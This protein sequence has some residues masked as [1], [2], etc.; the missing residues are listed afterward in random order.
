MATMYPRGSVGV[1]RHSPATAQRCAEEQTAGCQ[2]AA[3]LKQRVR[4]LPDASL[5]TTAV[6]NQTIEPSVVCSWGPPCIICLTIPDSLMMRK[7][8]N[9]GYAQEA[10]MDGSLN[11]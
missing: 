6:G 10:R 9:S 5:T 4:F 11:H 2:A 3:G 1:G 8:M 7:G